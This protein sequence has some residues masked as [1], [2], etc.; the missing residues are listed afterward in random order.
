[1]CMYIKQYDAQNT[2][3]REGGEKKNKKIVSHKQLSR[4]IDGG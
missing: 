4:W 3:I 2:E 1:M